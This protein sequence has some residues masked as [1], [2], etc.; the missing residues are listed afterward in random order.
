LRNKEDAMAPVLFAML[1]AQLVYYIP[2]GID[3]AQMLMFGLVLGMI[4]LEQAMAK[5]TEQ[6][7]IGEKNF[8]HRL[9]R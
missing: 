8:S 6:L 2:Y 3:Y 9:A 5:S 1:V 4:S 7:S